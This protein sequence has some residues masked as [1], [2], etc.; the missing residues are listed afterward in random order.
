MWVFA[1]MRPA[2]LFLIIFGATSAISYAQSEGLSLNQ[3]VSR[4]EQA[5]AAERD[6][7]LAYTVEREYQLAPAGAA[8]PSA[9]VVADVSFTRV[10]CADGWAAAAGT[11]NSVRVLVLLEQQGTAWQA[12]NVVPTP[13]IGVHALSAVA[14]EYLVP[15]SVLAKLAAGLHLS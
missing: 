15:P 9:D 8:K 3:I 7:N 11:E 12:V 5:R 14:A 10:A 4:M 6:H 2:I 13:L 1:R